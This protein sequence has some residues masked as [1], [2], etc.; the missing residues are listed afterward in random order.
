M[1]LSTPDLFLKA[2]ISITGRLTGLNARER[3]AV[4]GAGVLLTGLAGWTLIWQPLQ[5]ARQSGYE[6]IAEID[7][8]IALAQA[9]GPAFGERRRPPQTEAP[10]ALIT[11]TASEAGLFIRRLE[12]EGSGFAVSFDQAP[13]DVMI[14]W[15]AGLE[16]DHTLAVTTLD[17][18][19]QTTP[20]V[21][22]AR[23]HLEVRS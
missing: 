14:A 15:L 18:E 23:M 7:R 22:S 10:A 3:I 13:F 12:P 20:G 11:R 16:A 21:V 5:Q 17:L 4:A 6:R 2:R 8:A 19:R 9:A 1:K